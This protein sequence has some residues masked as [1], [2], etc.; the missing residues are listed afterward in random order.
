VLGALAAGPR[1]AV[2]FAAHEL[3]LVDHA[4]RM[5]FDDFERVC[6]HWRD[7]AD[8]DGPAQRHARDQALRRVDLAPG[9]DGVGHLDGYLTPLGHATVAGAL[10]RIERELFDAD[11]AS[12]RELHDD[13]LSADLLAR[14]GPRAATTLS[15]RWPPGP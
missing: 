15:W 5:R 12:A 10:D 7:A 9:L 1:T 11:W 3:L 4:R 2:E 6:A 14:S 8:P 13:T